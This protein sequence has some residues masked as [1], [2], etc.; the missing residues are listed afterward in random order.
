MVWR[1][2]FA[3]QLAR[4]FRARSLPPF[5]DTYLLPGPAPTVG[6]S[7]PRGVGGPAAVIR[8]EEMA[9]VGTR[10]FIGVGFAGALSAALHPGDVVVCDRAIRD[11]G[12]SH[13]YAHPNV[14]ARASV[15]LTRW[16]TQALSEADLP[17][18]TGESWTTD[19]PYRETG[20][21]LRHYRGKGVLT[22]EMEA[23]ALFILGRHRGL[24]VASVLVVSDV[25]TDKEWLPHFHRVGD[26]LEA[27]ALALIR[28]SR[29]G[30][31]RPGQ[32]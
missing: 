1:P 6:I 2:G 5:S 16:V 10:E 21:E 23:S 19:A 4:R 29:R 22:V 17:F 13:H 24:H 18:Q 7:Y 9:A 26:K 31:A 28:A 3:R 30:R 14:A 12:T 27:V 8:C 25:L 32:G 15:P 20:M 11:E